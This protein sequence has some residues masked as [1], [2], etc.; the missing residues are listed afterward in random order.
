MDH[1][2]SIDSR[3]WLT[4]AGLL[5]LSFGYALY[6]IGRKP[7]SQV[8]GPWYTKYTSLVLKYHLL[9]GD[10]PKYVHRLHNKYGDT[11]RVAPDEVYVT[12]LAAVKEIYS[13]KE[14]FRK[15]KWYTDLTTNE[16][17]NMFNTNNIELHRKYRRLLSGPMSETSLKAVLPLVESRVNLTIQR[18]REEMQK[19]GAADVF[20]WWLFMA[21]DIIGELAFGSSFQTLEQGKK[22]EYT[23]SLEEIAPL[24]ALRSVA[25]SLARL[26]IIPVPLFKRAEDA[27]RRMEGYARESLRRYENLVATDPTSVKQ[28]LFTNA[29][30][31]A[32][33]DNMGFEEI[34]RNAHTYIVAGSD[35]TSNTLTYL[36]WA[37][38]R[39]PEVKAALLAELR[40]LPDG[41][42]DVELRPL[43]YLAQVIEETLRLHTAVPSG[44]PRAVPPGGAY[45]SGYWF[46]AGTT[47]AAQAYTL[48]RDPDVFPDPERFDP[49][50]WAAPTRAMKDS[51]MAWGAG[52]RIC[53]GLHLARIELRLATARFFL[54]FPNAKVARSMGMTD[55]EMEPLMYFLSSPSGHR[56]L[57]Q[58]E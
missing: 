13:V 19:T 42:G 44:L 46:D 53:I 49:A 47:V 6:Q 35:T 2:S 27:S 43:P 38:C 23:K 51:L 24:S 33:D 22:N 45:L 11:V 39:H 56:C 41:F 48:H 10:Q 5:L 37:V 16:S 34:L 1:F 50:R 4:G 12:D 8:P 20:K 28:T 32:E 55:E 30:R 26:T 40:T 57:I 17:H 58:A 18:M 9:S 31:A 7:T 25:P 21:T 29:F 15:T 3:I 36:V 52:S 14:V 54:A